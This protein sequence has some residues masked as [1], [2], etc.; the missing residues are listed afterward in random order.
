MGNDTSLSKNS[1]VKNLLDKFQQ[2]E[3][4]TLEDLKI[5]DGFVKEGKK[6]HKD[7]SDKSKKP[8]E[9]IELKEEKLNNKDDQENENIKIIIN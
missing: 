8:K 1:Q 6:N 9:I 5:L 3:E 4:T 2:S 7:I